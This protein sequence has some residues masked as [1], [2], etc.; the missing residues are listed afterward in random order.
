MGLKVKS[1][2]E[3]DP[4]LVAQAQDELSQMLQEKYPE[5]ELTR[6]VIHDIV[7]FL[8]AVCAG[9]NQTEINRVLESRS[10]L[11]IQQNPTLADP[12]LVDHVL[13]NFRITRKTGTRARGNITIVIQGDATMVIA[14]DTL[15]IANGLNFRTNVPISARPPGTVT[16]AVNDRVL[17][18]RGDGTFEFTVPATA[19]VVGESSNVRTNTKF[20][21][22]SP[23]QRFV[24]AFS[25]DDFT[26]GT[27]DETN[28]QLVN[29]L[30]AG[31]AAPVTAGRVN[32]EALIRSQP[33][34]A[35]IKHVSIIG[36]GDAEMT[37]DQHWIFPVS[38]GGRIDVYGHMDAAPQTVAIRR[39]ARLIE[40]RTSDSIWQ[41]T[42]TRDDAPGFYEVAAIRTL[43][44]PTDSAGCTVVSDQRGYDLGDDTWK[45]DIQLLSEAL[46]TRYQTAVI[47]FADELTDV[48]DMTVGDSQD[49]NVNLLTQKLIGDLQDFL[50]S[51]DHRSLTADIVVKSAVPCFT[52]INFDVVKN[53]NESAPDL[54][55]IR[56]AIADYVNNLDFPGVLYSS[57][58]MDVIHN[59]LTGSQAVSKLDMHGNIRRPDGSAVV[60]RSPHSLQIPKSPSTLVTAR[61]TVFVLSPE[62]VGVNVVNRSV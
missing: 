53:A 56:V 62:D 58:I 47:Q 59:Y 44:E 39:S 13:S 41:L 60:I 37:R 45:P 43:T 46:Y 8:H 50:C 11:A 61:T 54:D 1:I 55:K 26:G 18:P 4:T 34:F 29:R 16:T 25:A 38:G 3:L 52:S 21:P 2:D 32:I 15:Y 14:A 48:S 6:G 33:V 23:P 17:E 9:I 28:T 22:E 5:V 27:V 49:Y 30:E 12:E 24:V 40:K 51:S 19:E 57:Q 7:V 36:F 35:D 42:I 31:I 20:V 10:L